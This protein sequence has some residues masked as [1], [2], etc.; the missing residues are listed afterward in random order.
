M[1][2]GTAARRLRAF[3]SFVFR[4][5]TIVTLAVIAIGGYLVHEQGDH[6]ELH[7]RDLSENAMRSAVKNTFTVIIA[8]CFDWPE[9]EREARCSRS[10]ESLDVAGKFSHGWVAARWLAPD[11]VAFAFNRPEHLAGKRLVI[12]VD[13]VNMKFKCIPGPEFGDPEYA[14][15]VKSA[16]DLTATPTFGGSGNR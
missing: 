16:C 3:M 13:F 10:L 7:Q 12:A 1:N 2:S 5:A 4:P 11:Q 9:S 14:L 6:Y 8:N 15:R